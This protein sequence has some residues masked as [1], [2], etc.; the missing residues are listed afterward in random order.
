MTD[1]K[2]SEAVVEEQAAEVAAPEVEEKQQENPY[3]FS[4]PYT[5]QDSGD[6]DDSEDEETATDDPGDGGEEKV[7]EPVA[8]QSNSKQEVES[9]DDGPIDPSL[10]PQ[11]F[12]DEELAAKVFGVIRQQNAQ[13]AKLNEMLASAGIMAPRESAIS[14]VGDQFPDVFGGKGSGTTPEQ[15]EARQRLS[16]AA[17]IVRSAYV[18]RGKQPPGWE[19][20]LR[21]AMGV[22][23]PDLA[24]KAASADL[25][26][27][28]RES[29]RISRPV[30]RETAVSPEERAVRAA[31]KFMLENS[32]FA[33]SV[34]DLG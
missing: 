13:I 20:A 25:K 19:E 22:E 27:K 34:P 18:K 24:S 31:R 28:R 21:V 5:E 10:N 16:E 3:D 32:A 4:D 14:K 9:S 6:E 12:L 2:A 11:D 8:P 29:Q 15:A 33:N 17:D 7:E 30:Q 1:E 23:F 26:A